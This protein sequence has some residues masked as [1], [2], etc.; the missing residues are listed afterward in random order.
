[1]YRPN[2]LHS[3]TKP[4]ILTWGDRWGAFQQEVLPGLYKARLCTL[5]LSLLGYCASPDFRK[6]LITV[7]LAYHTCR[8]NTQLQ[9]GVC[10]TPPL[11][12]LEASA[13]QYAQLS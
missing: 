10:G 8:I 2:V 6:H 13:A 9:V 12:K 5:R 7:C 1:M 4:W 11:G 3:P